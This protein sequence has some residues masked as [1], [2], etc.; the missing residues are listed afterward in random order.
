MIIKKR[1]ATNSC[2]NTSPRD[3]I[4]TKPREPMRS[5]KEIATLFG[6]TRGSSLWNLV[7]LGKFPEPDF[8]VDRVSKNSTKAFWKLSVVEAELK[9]RKDKENDNS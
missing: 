8:V 1:V 9:K 5:T 3:N 2:L 7:S 4:S 6:F